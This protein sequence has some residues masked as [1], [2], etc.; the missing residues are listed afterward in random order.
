MGGSI[1][2]AITFQVQALQGTVQEK[3]K[4]TDLKETSTIDQTTNRIDFFWG[5]MC[6]W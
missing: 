4:Q 5:N 3:H 1:Y 6:M 2:G